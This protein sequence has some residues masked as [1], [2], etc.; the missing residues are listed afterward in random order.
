MQ[1]TPRNLR[2]NVK[3]TRVEPSPGGWPPG[4]RGWRWRF[5]ISPISIR[6]PSGELPD[7]MHIDSPA[8]L[9]QI[10]AAAVERQG[11]PHRRARAAELKSDGSG[12]VAGLSLLHARFGAHYLAARGMPGV[13]LAFGHGHLGLTLA[14]ITAER[15]ARLL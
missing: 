1:D 5:A 7:A 11:A 2:S 3:S 9:M 15:V 8:D 4:P 6:A 13:K 10:M 14:A 12:L